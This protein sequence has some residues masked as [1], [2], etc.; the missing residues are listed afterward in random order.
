MFLYNIIM[1]L[2][3]CCLVQVPVAA[4]F[5]QPFTS[6]SPKNQMFDSPS[7]AVDCK[8]IVNPRRYSKLSWSP[9]AVPNI[10]VQFSGEIDHPFQVRRAISATPISLIS[11]VCGATIEPYQIVVLYTPS[12]QNSNM[13][14]A[15]KIVYGKKF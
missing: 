15:G 5:I 14:F 4:T 11:A 7:N 3:Y 9:I 6:L 2:N 8:A 12:Q 13:K 10:T 1:L